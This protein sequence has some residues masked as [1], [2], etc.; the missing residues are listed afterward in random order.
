[1]VL[2]ELALLQLQVVLVLMDRE[3]DEQ[4]DQLVGRLPVAV[5]AVCIGEQ[6]AVVERG[7][8]QQVADQDDHAVQ[9]FEDAVLDILC[10]QPDH[11]LRHVGDQ[12]VRLLEEAER[13]VEIFT[14]LLAL[15]Q[16]GQAVELFELLRHFDV[17]VE[18]HF[19][20][21]LLQALPDEVVGVLALAFII[22]NQ[23]QTPGRV[24][25]FDVFGVKQIDQRITVVFNQRDG[26]QRRLVQDMFLVRTVGH[27]PVH[28]DFV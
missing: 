17:R 9:L 22:C 1:M 12:S 2:S 15:G 24:V 4:T 8:D 25:L 13:H 7:L 10:K 6:V 28:V 11:D 14:L 26:R 27:D 18:P 20:R 23:A 21:I 16:D 3:L 19:V 5:D